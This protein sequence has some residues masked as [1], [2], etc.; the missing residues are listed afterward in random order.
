MEQVARMSR[1]T[2]KRQLRDLVTLLREKAREAATLSMLIRAPAI[3]H[4]RRGAAAAYGDISD[5][6]D[7]VL[8][9][10]A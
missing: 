2:I 3:R 5:Q 9:R 6:V 10:I 7:Q 1:G 4:S 8:R